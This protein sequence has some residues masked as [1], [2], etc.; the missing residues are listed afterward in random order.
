MSFSGTVNSDF[1]KLGS[2]PENRKSD[3]VNF[4]ATDFESIKDSLVGYINAVY[5]Q[6]FNNFY[7]SESTVFKIYLNFLLHII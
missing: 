5:P 2:I 3:L 4:A 6:D 1:M 7:D